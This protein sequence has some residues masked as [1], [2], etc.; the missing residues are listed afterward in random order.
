[1]STLKW[2][3]AGVLLGAFVLAAVAKLVPALAPG[4]VAAK[5]PTLAG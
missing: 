4:A 1:M 2:T 3:V 5:L